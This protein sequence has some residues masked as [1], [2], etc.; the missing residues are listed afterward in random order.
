[1]S[2]SWLLFRKSMKQLRTLHYILQIVPLSVTLMLL[3]REHKDK[4]LR[5]IAG[6]WSITIADG[7]RPD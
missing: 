5:R 6:L 2:I 7:H 3:R 1:M 4:E